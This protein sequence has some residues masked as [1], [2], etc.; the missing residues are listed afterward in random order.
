LRGGDMDKFQGNFV[1]HKILKKQ[2]AS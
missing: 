2:I 1:S